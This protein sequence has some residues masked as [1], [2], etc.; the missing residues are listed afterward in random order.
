M[1]ERGMTFLKISVYKKIDLYIQI[2][3]QM[4]IQIL[5]VNKQRHKLNLTLF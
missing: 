4:Y 2:F 3:K 1:C 5:K